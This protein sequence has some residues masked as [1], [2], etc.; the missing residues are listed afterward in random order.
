MNWSRKTLR[1]I[2]DNYDRG[3]RSDAHAHSCPWCGQKNDSASSDSP[4]KRPKIGDISLC[5]RCGGIGQFDASGQVRKAPPGILAKLDLEDR[6]EL[7]RVQR[8]IREQRSAN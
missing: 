7:L 6:D 5:I 2:V 3:D 4:E 1:R 8:L